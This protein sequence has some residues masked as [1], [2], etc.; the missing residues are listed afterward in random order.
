MGIT[1]QDVEHVAELARLSFNEEELERLTGELNSILSH[2]EQLRQVSTQG[3]KP[4][5]HA[6]ELFNVFREDQVLPSMEPEKAL[7]NAPKRSRE[8][9]QVPR[10]IE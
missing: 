3:V 6:M 10:V 7:A 9:F 1:R 2:M 4:T 5:T 8:S